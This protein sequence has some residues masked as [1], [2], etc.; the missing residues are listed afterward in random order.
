VESVAVRAL[1]WPPSTRVT[2]PG[3]TATDS[4]VQDG[5]WGP[6]P[7]E[8]PAVMAANPRPATENLWAVARGNRGVMGYTRGERASSNPRLHP[9]RP[10]TD[11]TAAGR[12]GGERLGSNLPSPGRKRQ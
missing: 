12:P 10:A 2:C 3:A 1:P 7:L 11:P 4:T 6:P 8:Q 5:V 9:R